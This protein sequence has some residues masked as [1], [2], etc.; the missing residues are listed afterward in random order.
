MITVSRPLEI[1]PD[2]VC[3]FVEVDGSVSVYMEGEELSKRHADWLTPAVAAAEFSWRATFAKMWSKA[4]SILKA[5]PAQSTQALDA[6]AA[7][8]SISAPTPPA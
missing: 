3:A 6:P 5:P 2:A 1:P 8:A 7:D 4:T